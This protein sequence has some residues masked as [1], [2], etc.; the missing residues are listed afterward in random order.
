MT[1]RPDKENLD[2]FLKHL[3]SISYG[4]ATVKFTLHDG[5]IAG[6]D[7]V[8]TTRGHKAALKKQKEDD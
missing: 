1:E 3:K 2:T 4:D 5:W 7:E 6:W 8:S